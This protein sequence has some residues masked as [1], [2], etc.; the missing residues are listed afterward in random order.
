MSRNKEYEQ[1]AASMS[2]TQLLARLTGELLAS[3]RVPRNAVYTCCGSKGG[4][5]SDAE[6]VIMLAMSPLSVSNSEAVSCEITS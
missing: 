3:K 2:T 4:Q 6:K 1:L 5:L